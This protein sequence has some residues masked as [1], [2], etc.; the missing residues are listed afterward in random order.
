MTLQKIK[1][2]LQGTVYTASDTVRVIVA[3]HPLRNEKLE[4]SLPAG[5]SI[6]EL[7]IQSEIHTRVSGLAKAVVCY[8]NGHVIE[9]DDWK[10]VRPK[11]GTIIVFRAVTEG[12]VVAAIG[13]IFS[14]VSSALF[15]A[16]GGLTLLGSVVM[17]GAA[18]GFQY[19]LNALFPPA[20]PIQDQSDNAKANP[21]YSITG[22]RNQAAQWE[23]IPQ[24]LGQHRV[25]PLFGSMPYTESVGE[26]QYIR[27][28]F[29]FG[30]GPMYV[31]DFKIG[32]TPLGNYKDYSIETHF[33]IPNEAPFTIFP[34]VRRE[35]VP[36]IEIRNTD[37]WIFRTTAPNTNEI[38]LDIVWPNGLYVLNMKDGKRSPWAQRFSFVYRLV[39][40]PS[41]NTI[42][43]LV[44]SERTVNVVRRNVVMGNLPAG[45]YEYGIRK[46]SADDYNNDDWSFASQSIL[47]AARSVSY[48]QPIQ[49]DK[50]LCV[51][52][53]RIRA[54]DQL[55]GT[56][57]NFNA[58]CTTIV[59]KQVNGNQWV[60][61]NQ[62]RNPADLFRH[63][64]QG[65]ANERPRAD[66]QIDL[67]A[68]IEWA[69]YCAQNGY[70]YDKVLMTQQSVHQTIRE[71][72]AA[73][74]A[75]PVYRDGKWSVVWDQKDTPPVQLF[76]PRNSW[77]FE[78]SFQ[79]VDIPHAWRINFVNRDKGYVEDERI[80]YADGYNASNATKFEGLQFPGVTTSDAVWRHGRYY[81]AEL[82]HRPERI[83]L[84]VD[85]EGL[86][87]TRGDRVRVQHDAALIGQISG[88]V[89]AMDGQTVTLDELVTFEAGKTYGVRYRLKDG[90]QIVREAV[91]EGETNTFT[92]SGSTQLPQEGNLLSFGET[93]RET[94][95]YRVVELSS[96]EDFT[97]RVTLVDDAPQIYLA[98]QGAIPPFNS[99]VTAP[100]DPY[101][102]APTDLQV[103]QE[104]YDDAGRW[105]ARI[106]LSW[107]VPRAGRVSS[108]EVQMRDKNG[109][110]AWRTLASLPVTQTSYT[111]A[112]LDESIYT[113]RVR[114]IFDTGKPSSWLTSE[115][116]ATTSI[117]EPPADVLNFN[118]NVLGERSTLSWN[119][120]QNAK[121][122][123]I[124]RAVAGVDASWNTALPLGAAVSNTTMEVPTMAGTFF[125]KAVRGNGIK[126]KNATSISSNIAGMINMNVVEDIDEINWPGDLN[127]VEILNGSLKLISMNVMDT[128][129]TLDEVVSLDQGIGKAGSLVQPNGYY[130]F[131][132]SIDLGHVYPSRISATIEAEGNDLRNVMDNWVTLD[133][134]LTLDSTAPENW[135]VVLEY[136][137][138]DGDG[139]WTD[140]KPLVIGDVSAR[141]IE[142]RLYLFGITDGFDNV[143]SITP[144]VHSVNVTVDMPDRPHGEKDIVIP[145]TGRRISFD[146]PFI[147]LKA[148]S[149]DDESLQ[150]GDR[151]VITNKD[152]AGFDIQFFNS[153]GQ[154]VSRTIDYLALGYGFRQ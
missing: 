95:I 1:T 47:T 55:N 96:G 54:S 32:E 7:A 121:E 109:G 37:N 84:T 43:D 125:I 5:L 16:G 111:I 58:V 78:S 71:I 129:T 11:A 61:G 83:T 20:K 108:F 152:A 98:D 141:V 70:W 17:S 62:T 8:V 154:P 19:L 140:W 65:P 60:T 13:A 75:V 63:V 130:Y 102:I 103:S 120:V 126:S 46:V 9:N 4:L 77:G 148:L 56:L 153:A 2:Q 145:V 42:P 57:D 66:S 14:A 41:W 18:F 101:F 100:I 24:V 73:G 151:K 107:L 31:G 122:Y 23:A 39:D 110:G 114:N 59:A 123:E 116:I 128:W 127:R 21:A 137:K 149:T 30:Y 36:N 52:A 26:D 15:A 112:G 134:V 139:E 29:V 143:S 146:P 49:F 91:G 89:I 93:G 34:D 28:F 35:D 45:Q 72:C 88:R 79:Y 82:E 76:T 124:R 27:Q 132:E 64:L 74:R 104:A 150:P 136:R 3:S 94:S 131:D 115:D 53:I 12:P 22:S 90:T 33:G 40:A 133:S 48:V 138:H 99:N 50:P 87:L 6:H 119:A 10:K 147:A 135:G 80:V 38:S 118:I 81:L 106:T 85:F 69:N 92:I 142:F 86:V 25:T 144:F 68:L 97:T 113:F 51:T 44:L 117:L 67:Q 105:L